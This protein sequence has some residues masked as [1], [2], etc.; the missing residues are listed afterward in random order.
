[1]LVLSRN[2]GQEIVIGNNIRITIVA[3]KGD[4]V[5]VGVV[6]PKDVSVHRLEVWQA[7]HPNGDD[8][9]GVPERNG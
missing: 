2:T 4:K 5:R 9:V 1:M 6:A 8:H 7:I 3:V